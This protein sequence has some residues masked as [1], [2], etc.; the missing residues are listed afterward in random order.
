[1]VVALVSLL[2]MGFWIEYE[3]LYNTYGGPL[4]ENS[5]PNSAIGVLLL[6]LGLSALLYKLRRPLRLIT[7]ELVVIYA[8]LVLA[9]PLMTQGLWHRLFGLVVAIPHSQDF[10]S[11]ESLPPMLWPHGKNLIANGRFEQG[12]SGALHT[13][14][15]T[16][17]WTNMTWRGKSWRVPVL[18]NQAGRRPGAALTFVMHRYDP[19]GREVLIPG[20]KHL[21]S[22]LVQAEGLSADSAYSLTLQ[23]D[24]AREIL[25]LLQSDDTRPSFTLTNGFC[26]IG[27]NPVTI[28]LELTNQLALRVGLRGTGRL[29]IHDV[30]F[31]NVEGVESGYTGRH[32]IPAND[33]A[34]FGPGERNATVIRPKHLLSPSGLRYLFTGFIPLDQWIKPAAAWTALVA[35]LFCGFLGLNLLMRKQWVEHERFTFPLTVFPRHLLHEENGRLTIF[36]NRVMW[37]GFACVLPLVIWKGLAYYIPAIPFFAST[38]IRLADYVHSQVMKAFLA[39][40]NID[41]VTGLRVAFCVM[42]IALLVETDILFSLWLTFFAFQLWKLVGAVINPT[43][44]VGYPWEHQQS[45]GGYLAFAALALF[46]GRQHLRRALRLAFR[47]APDTANAGEARTYRWALLLVLTSV[48]GIVAWSLW[49]RMGAAAGLLFFG[50]LLICGFAASKI[51]AEM[52]AP[53]GYMT[54]YFGMQFV[55]AV[56]GFPLFHSTGMLVATIAS[57]FMC[58]TC[59][60][61]IAPVQVEMLELGRHFNV[62]SRDVGAGLALGLFGGLFIGGFVLLCWM[63]G[64]GANNLRTA[65]PYQQ[66]NYLGVFRTGELNAD[67]AFESGTLAL[68]PQTQPLNIFANPDAKGLAIGAG[69]TLLLAGLRALFIWFPIHPLGYVLASTFFMKSMWFYFL[70]AWLTRQILFRLGGAQSIRRGLVPF[71]VGAFLACIASIVI[72]DVVGVV[73]RLQGV[74]EV[75]SGIP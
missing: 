53:W 25:L 48:I 63:Y 5:P 1:M 62:R 9:A 32:L 64:F 17:Q 47:G 34:Q 46:M 71:S 66:E 12:L 56:G 24:D 72:W 75:Y 15:D 57:G 7:A 6:V 2:L 68:D 61:L 52:G 45:M 42:A 49:T 59:F 8:A 35:A 69:V 60:L 20:E 27:V 4:A 36:R 14:A 73:L 38:D 28:P 50:Y 31:M 40:I 41:H 10:K 43:R 22:L 74:T 54:P 11:Y 29:A 44:F 3:E 21:V 26:R 18:D 67:R 16:L 13:G 30:E 33:L 39:D 65:W 58:T 23:A 37:L 19:Q 51:R 55:A 70:A